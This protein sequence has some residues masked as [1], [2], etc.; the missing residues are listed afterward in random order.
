MKKVIFMIK[1]EILLNLMKMAIQYRK[2]LR[3]AQEV[4]MEADIP[5]KQVVIHI[6]IIILLLNL[7][8]LQEYRF[9]ID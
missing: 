1:M 5:H 3:M 7:V 4:G 9:M 8:I 6:L 2:I